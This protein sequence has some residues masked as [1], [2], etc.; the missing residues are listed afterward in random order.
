MSEYPSV[1]VTAERHGSQRIVFITV[2]QGA[3]ACTFSLSQ[4]ET[5][6]LADDLDKA[7]R[8]PLSDLPAF[9]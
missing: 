5:S 1:N 7:A 8:K 3:V 2:R 4:D 6:I 9:K